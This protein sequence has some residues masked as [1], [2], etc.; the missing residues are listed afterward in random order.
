MPT[1]N[2]YRNY[3]E[4]DVINLYAFSGALPVNKGTL[5]QIQGSG[6]VPSQDPSE[7]LGSPG[8]SYA[9]TVSQRYGV[10]PKVS[11]CG[12]GS[13]TPLGITLLDI[14]ETD[15]NGEQLKFNPRK[16][17]ELEAVISGQAVP[18]VRKGVFHYSG[19]TGTPTAGGKL[20][21][22][23]NGT[24]D[25]LAQIASVQVG[26]ALGAKDSVGFTVVLLDI[27]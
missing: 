2:P 25:C 9:N 12:T 21:V 13:A 6:F 24:I 7:M 4:K 5:V 8:A 27:G 14:K 11:I 19:I 20:Y 17:H 1:L 3:N 18:I 16:A 15:E 23:V 10:T 26:I 22:G